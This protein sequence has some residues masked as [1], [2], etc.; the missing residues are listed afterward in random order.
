MGARGFLPAPV[1]PTTPPLRSRCAPP[2][3]QARLREQGPQLLHFVARVKRGSGGD[4]KQLAAERPELVPPV[5]D[6]Q[7]GDY[8][9]SISVPANGSLP[10]S[11][12]EQ[13]G[14]AAG[15]LVPSL[16]QWHSAA[17]PAQRLPSSGLK[18]LRLTG[19]HRQA[20]AINQALAELGADKL[21]R[22]ETA[23]SA[24]LPS[25]HAAIWNTTHLRGTRTLF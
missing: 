17:M 14:S 8:S 23:P 4:L 21:I 2:L 7:R 25:L 16:I 5:M 6:L 9:W 18:L 10:W 3:L 22:V 24:A 15:G 12:P 19:R 13:N 20:E 11:G 1:C